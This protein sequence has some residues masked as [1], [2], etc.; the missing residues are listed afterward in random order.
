MRR[1]G[2]LI[3]GRQG[4]QRPIR[5]TLTVLLIIPVVSLIALWVY[6]ASTTVGGVIAKRGSPRKTRP[7]GKP[8][9]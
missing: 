6:A 7:L 5:S 2:H 4:R 3:R 1:W 9:P 8:G